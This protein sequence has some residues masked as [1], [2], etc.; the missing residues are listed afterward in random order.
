MPCFFFCFSAF[1]QTLC[2]AKYS[3]SILSNPNPSD[4]V[5]LEEVTKEPANKKSSTSKPSQR[6]LSDQEC[7]FQAQSKWKGAGKFILKLKEQVQV[8]MQYFA[9]MLQMVCDQLNGNLLSMQGGHN[10]HESRRRGQTTAKSIFPLFSEP[11]LLIPLLNCISYVQQWFPHSLQIQSNLYLLPAF[12]FSKPSGCA[13]HV[14]CHNKGPSNGQN[15]KATRIK[16]PLFLASE[17]VVL[18]L[19]LR[20]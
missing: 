16:S 10:R 11:P 3:Y 19:Y 5:L 17:K 15:L 20:L 12:C 4:Y 9:A 2:K 1:K 13:C 18:L 8:K 14:P 6:I 7:V